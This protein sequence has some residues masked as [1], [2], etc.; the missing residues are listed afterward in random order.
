[1]STFVLKQAAPPAE[2]RPT[3]T[4][5]EKLSVAG[6]LP[7]QANARRMME[8]SRLSLPLTATARRIR[9]AWIK[10]IIA[11]NWREFTLEEHVGML[12]VNFGG[13]MPR[14]LVERVGSIQKIV[15][16]AE[17][18]IHASYTDPWITVDGLIVGGWMNGKV[19]L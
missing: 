14:E 11:S 1:M 4:V 17:I 10:R 16:E 9:W 2:F 7:D 3:Q 15:P 13:A 19:I 12:A 6:F 5:A 8:A 18:R